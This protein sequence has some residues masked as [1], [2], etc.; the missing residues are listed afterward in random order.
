MPADVR[1][2]LDAERARPAPPDEVVERVRAAAVAAIAG[3][4]G[5]G[6]GGATP[7][8]GPAPEGAGP[9]SGVAPASTFAAWLRLGLPSLALGL[10]L[11]G[12]IGIVV[13]RG[14]GAERAP[15]RRTEVG[16]SEEVVRPA[17][18]RV[19][20]P[21]GAHAPPVP[22][23]A[24]ESPAAPPTADPRS[25]PP[26][27]SALGTERALLERAQAAMARHDRAEASRALEA[28]AR[29]FPEGALAREREILR[30]RLGTVEP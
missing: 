14:D 5:G 25:L 22:A 28:H 27:P 16:P 23:P 24:P 26:A 11:G 12:V 17:V 29:R 3:G 21:A 4:G 2:V 30:A 6:A 7:R 1:S 18:R 15:P 19:A 10:V 9:G 8:P 13:T 20:E